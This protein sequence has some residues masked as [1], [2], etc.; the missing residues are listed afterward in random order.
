MT[1]GTYAVVTPNSILAPPV[2]CEIECSKLASLIIALARRRAPLPQTSFFSLSPAEGCERIE[3]PAAWVRR[4]AEWFAAGKPPDAPS[5]LPFRGAVGVY[6]R[7]KRQRNERRAAWCGGYMLGMLAQT[8][9]HANLPTRKPPNTQTYP[10]A[11]PQSH[12]RPAP[13]P[14]LTQ[15]CTAPAAHCPSPLQIPLGDTPPCKQFLSF[16]SPENL[17]TKKFYLYL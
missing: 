8:S 10:H 5:H 6:T 15:P 12:T 11:S 3:Q 4:Q 1:V 7:I 17:R 2:V 9:Q 13:N 14:S 16:F